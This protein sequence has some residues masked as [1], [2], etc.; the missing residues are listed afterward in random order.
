MTTPYQD[1]IHVSRYA[2]YNDEVK[3]R[4]TW[5]ETVDRVGVTRVQLFI[6]S[7]ND[8]QGLASDIT[9]S[10]TAEESNATTT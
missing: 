4:E 9:E 8:E 5:D 10:A 6:I 1:Y 3:R 7:P 2:R